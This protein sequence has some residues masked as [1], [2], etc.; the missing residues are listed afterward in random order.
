MGRRRNSDFEAVGCAVYL[1]LGLFTGLAVA[2]SVVSF[3]LKILPLLGIV[4]FSGL[5]LWLLW[6]GEKAKRRQARAADVLRRHQ[7]ETDV[8][9]QLRAVRTAEVLEQAKEEAG[10]KW[11]RLREAQREAQLRRPTLE[12]PYPEKLR[13]QT[14]K[15]HLVRSK[16]EA[17]IADFLHYHGLDYRYENPLFGQG[18]TRYPDFTICDEY[19]GRTYY[20]EHLGMLDK[21]VYR[22]R[23]RQKLDWYKAVG[24]VPIED[25][26]GPVGTLI[27]TKGQTLAAVRTEAAYTISKLLNAHRAP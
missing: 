21:T 17:I 1:C 7:E 5:I 15:G 24:I 26:G 13:H 19:T 6:T 18:Y 12:V 27:T 20:W 8:Q 2:T 11:F 14:S 3:P 23:W 9:R 22:R 10:L 4:S 16:S 25:G